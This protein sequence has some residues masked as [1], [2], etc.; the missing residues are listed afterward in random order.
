MGIYAYGGKVAGGA[1]HFKR[2]AVQRRKALQKK[3]GHEASYRVVK[4]P[5]KW[6]ELKE[7]YGEHAKYVVIAKRK[8][9]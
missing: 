6:G 8:R 3:Y 5:S 2:Y 9:R 7:E 4:I 1:F